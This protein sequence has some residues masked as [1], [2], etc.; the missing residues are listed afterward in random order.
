MIEMIIS[1]YTKIDNTKRR[2]IVVLFGK[3]LFFHFYSV[4]IDYYILIC[5]KNKYLN[6]TFISTVNKK[7]I[8]LLIFFSYFLIKKHFL[9][10]FNAIENE[11][12]CLWLG[13]TY[14]QYIQFND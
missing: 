12:L 2:K 3:V 4:F 9:C 11:K 8:F 6:F 5:I 13:K 1:L 14:F 10:I 7:L